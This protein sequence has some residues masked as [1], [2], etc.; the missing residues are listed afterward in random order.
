MTQAF[1][2][3]SPALIEASLST[4]TKVSGIVSGLAVVVFSIR[5]VLLVCF[6]GSPSQYAAALKELFI[7]FVALA[8]FAPLF[9]TLV[10]TTNE[11]SQKISVA[12]VVRDPGALDKI[13]DWV[14]EEAP[15]FGMFLNLG[16]MSLT[17]VVQAIFSILIA[18]ICSVA[19]IVLLY[20]FIT[21][22]LSGI[23]FLAGTLMTLC[24]WPIVWNSIG[25]LA[26]QLW[27]SFS[28]T[29]LAGIC[30][31]FIVKVMQVISPLFAGSLIKNFSTQGA[32]KSVSAVQSAY[33]AY[34]AYSRIKTGGAA[35]SGRKA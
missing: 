3:M 35:G 19:P 16:P 29:S 31:W 25:A 27:P 12:E 21:G 11:I 24:S 33:R 26:N 8:L 20:Q 15:F 7:F 34:Q 23:S 4:F 32:G 17:Y 13:F 10:L 2:P 1:A 14:G 9:R 30:F 28:Q 18:A 22:S 5:V 6:V